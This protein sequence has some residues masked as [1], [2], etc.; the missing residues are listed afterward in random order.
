MSRYV[1]GLTGG[2]AAGKSEVT[3]RFE[4]L[5]IVVADADL[6]ARAVVEAGSPALAQITARFGAGMLLPDGQLDRAR[7]RAHVFADPAE[8]AA[9][10]AIT[11]PAIR[12]LMQQQC[13]Q[14]R[15]P[16]AIA[17]IPLLTEVGGRKAYPWLDRV[18]LVDA[19]EGVQ[20]ARLMQRD[21]IDAALADRMIAAQASRT[22]RQAL[23]DDVVVNDGQPDDL[24]AQVEHL[25]AQYLGLAGG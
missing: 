7:L 2:I 19:P 13:E 6:A 22:Q 16:Y 3:R 10:E 25:H 8:R 11:H 12:R 20:H 5:G 15:S 17:A 4:A 24:Q 9:L 23:A 18:L 14:A 1:V 21:G